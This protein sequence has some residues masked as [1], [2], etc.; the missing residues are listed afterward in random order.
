MIKIVGIDPGLAATGIGIVRGVGV[1][2]KDYSFGSITTSKQSHLPERLDSLFTKLLQLLENEQPDLMIVEDIYSMRHYPKSGIVLGK[3]V[4]AV[5]I[6]AG[7]ASV[8]ATEVPVRQAK[9]ILTGNGAASK[10]QLEKAVRYHLNHHHPIRPNHASDAMGLALIGLFR[11][12]EFINAHGRRCSEDFLNHIP[13][14]RQ[15]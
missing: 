1:K 7:R 11:Y 6:A 8:P 9:Q 15:G 4:G 13:N 5:L 12:S 14:A 2:I 10:S 3:V